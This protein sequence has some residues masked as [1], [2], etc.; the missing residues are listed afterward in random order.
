MEIGQAIFANNNIYSYDCDEYIVALLRHLD[1]ELCRVMW[2]KNQQEYDSPFQNT[3]NSFIGENFE[4]HAYSWNEDEEQT[5]NFKCG[6]IEISWYKYL[7][8]GTTINGEYTPEQIINMYNI[9]LNEIRKIDGEDHVKF[10]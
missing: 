8:R 2:N 1:S 7:G 5:Y 4:V 10:A 3:G 6:D 9:C